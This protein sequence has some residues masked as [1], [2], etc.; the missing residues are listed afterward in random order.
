MTET[1]TGKTRVLMVDDI[2]E[3]LHAMMDILR[4]KYAIIAATDGEK[5][6]K[7]AARQPHP[8][9]I[10]LDIRMP[11]MDG[12]EVLRRL[13]ADPLTSDIPVIFVTALSEPEDE[14]KGLKMGA[15]DYITKPV[16]PDLLKVRMM[17]QLELQRYRRKP[18]LPGMAEGDAP[19]ANFNILVVDDVPENLHELIGALSD[20]YRILIANNGPKAIELAQGATPP[21][22]ILLDILMPEMDGYE[23][24]RRI[25]ATE[26]GK[27]I[28]I[29]FISV[30]D[31]PEK[32]I[33][34]FSIGA[35]DYITRPFDIDEARARIRTHLLLSRLQFSLELQVAQRTAALVAAN[36]QLKADEKA[37]QESKEKIQEKEEQ[38][39]LITETVTEVFWMADNKIENMFYVSPA[40]ERI[41]RRSCQSLCENPRSFIDAIHPEDKERIITELRE[42]Q[43]NK[44]S[45]DHE[46]RIIRPDKSI[47][48]IW[49][50]G[51]PVFEKTG[52]VKR[53]VGI[54]QDITDK[55]AAE[56]ELKQHRNYLEQLVEQRTAELEKK[57]VQLIHAAMHDTLTGLP[58]RSLFT[59]RLLQAISISKRSNQL[60]ALLYIDLDKFKPINDEFGHKTGDE[61][62]KEVANRLKS[63]VRDNDT[64]G[65]I[66]GDEFAAIIL[67]IKNQNDANLVAQKIIKTICNPIFINSKQIELGASIGISFYPK[68][69]NDPDTLMTKA[70]SAMYNVKKKSIRSPGWGN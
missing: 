53:C 68:D 45:F 26:V 2:A 54:A 6:L 70:D 3:N 33:M 22:L 19:Q 14:A 24:C 29:I 31:V 10:L 38:L 42:S 5:A 16:N 69:G 28:P 36:R 41:F 40:Y 39:R 15:A 63:C 12:Y 13:K 51:F 20:E 66:G 52:E 55:K 8:D 27:R 59:D 60:F 35:A 64:I 7:L 67:D 23:V 30:I 62:L 11:G 48:W 17:T 9:L 34:G 46:Y 21:D 43:I 18:I 1:I 57:Q 32:K 44:R 4:D 61:A 25:K 47:R 49:D 56:L 65:R 37:L 50:R 58:N